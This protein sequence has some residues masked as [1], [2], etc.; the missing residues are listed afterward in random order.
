MTLSV[1]S[2]AMLLHRDVIKPGSRLEAVLDKLDKLQGGRSIPTVHYAISRISHLTCIWTCS[3]Q[4]STTNHILRTLA[5]NLTV[6]K[7]LTLMNIMIRC[8]MLSSEAQIPHQKLPLQHL[9]P[10]FRTL[11]ASK[12]VCT[13]VALSFIAAVCALTGCVLMGPRIGRFDKNGR[14]VPMPGHSVPLSALGGLIL[15]F[16][17]FACNGTKQVL[18]YL[19]MSY[20]NRKEKKPNHLDPSGQHFSRW[21]W[22]GHCHGHREHGARHLRRGTRHA[23]L[24][25][26]RNRPRYWRKL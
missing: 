6:T 26:D 25:Q 4:D 16:G 20:E 19:R 10:I 15:V 17:F 13:N 23:H 8:L 1:V 22:R 21:R 11:C 14:A 9:Q 5:P 12:T 18:T 7:Q 3:R 2:Q 24:Q